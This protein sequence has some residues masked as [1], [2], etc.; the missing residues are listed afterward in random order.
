MDDQQLGNTIPKWEWKRKSY[1][2]KLPVLSFSFAAL[3]PQDKIS[4]NFWV[5]CSIVK[6][7]PLHSQCWRM[8][9]QIDPEIISNINGSIRVYWMT[10]Q[11]DRQSAHF[12]SVHLP[13]QHWEALVCFQ[14]LK[15]ISFFHFFLFSNWPRL[16]AIEPRL[17]KFLLFWACFSFFLIYFFVH[18]C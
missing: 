8:K 6:L 1:T 15:M 4:V 12:Y 11:T 14:Y 10:K 17:D 18:L 3:C 9:D 5:W 7:S 13:I 16:C 2:I